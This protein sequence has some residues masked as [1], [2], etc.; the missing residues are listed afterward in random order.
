MTSGT[1]FGV[2]RLLGGIEIK[3]V[4][5][6]NGVSLKKVVFVHPRDHD[7]RKETTSFGGTSPILPL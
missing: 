4:T 3:P 1:C 7:L 6:E 5:D 2:E